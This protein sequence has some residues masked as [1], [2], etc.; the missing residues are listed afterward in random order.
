[1]AQLEKITIGSVVVGTTGK[2]QV[3]IVAVKWHGN[4]V[5]ELRNCWMM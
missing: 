5:L 2:E 1:M 3:T 4:A